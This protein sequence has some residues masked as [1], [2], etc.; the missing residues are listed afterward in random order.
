MHA[1]ELSEGELQRVAIARVLHQSP[2]LAVL[3]ESVTAM[4]I[5]Q[6]QHMLEL[7]Q[8]AGISICMT[9]QI[10]CCST[11]FFRNILTISGDGRGSW[12]LHGS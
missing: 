6:G 3:D 12:T 10:D 9:G 5:K 11:A 2:L 7:L 1:G 8:L 4:S